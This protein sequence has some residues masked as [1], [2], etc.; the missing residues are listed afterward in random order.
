MAFLRSVPLV[1]GGPVVRG[2]KVFMRPPQMSDHA[3]W[4]ALRGG[5]ESFLR[6]WEPEWAADELSRS[7]FRRRLRYY[8]RDM[9]EGLG[10][11]FFIFRVHDSKLVGGITLS[12]ARRGVSQSISVGYWIGVPFA[13]QGLM[14][15]ALS[16]IVPFVFST[17]GFHRLEAACLPTNDPSRCLL[18]TSGFKYEGLA[19]Q[20]LRINGMWQDHLLFA[21]VEDDVRG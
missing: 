19:R 11:A 6:P 1:D 9:R 10:Y 4:A 16:A 7:A 20:Y 2:E 5:S 14:R 17:L 3:D 12:N 15:S 21:I 18:E 8:Q 13:R